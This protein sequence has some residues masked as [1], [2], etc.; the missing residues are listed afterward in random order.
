[1]EK[2][3]IAAMDEEKAIGKDGEIPWHY[4]EDVKH[5]KEK[6]TGHS[7]LMGRKTYESLPKDFRPLPGRENIVLTR[8]DPNLD[9]SVE[10]VNSLSEAY[11]A[12]ENKKLFIAGGASVYEQTLRE[13]DKMILT[14][15]PGTHDGDA[16]FP[17]WNKDNWEL[18][19]QKEVEGLLFEEFTSKD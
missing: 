16:F 13:A 12:A 4:S 1:M 6:T 18:I 15:I 7:V 8:S 2:I 14:H 5:F 11:E 3:I 19:S 10:I 9:E 17:D